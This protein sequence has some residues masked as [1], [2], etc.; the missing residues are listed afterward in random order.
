MALPDLAQ[1]ILTLPAEGLAFLLGVVLAAI[2]VLV[3]ETRLRYLVAAF[4]LIPAGI[5][6]LPLDLQTPWHYWPAASVVVFLFGLYKL[7]L[8][9]PISRR[10]Q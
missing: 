3:A 1:S 7:G 8:S 6:L 10:F 2:I 4:I 9:V 5:P